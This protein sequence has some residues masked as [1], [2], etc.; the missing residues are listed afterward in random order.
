MRF[1]YNIYTGGAY[2]AVL[3]LFQNDENNERRAELVEVDDNGGTY[4]YDV[5]EWFVHNMLTEKDWGK[6]KACLYKNGLQ[7]D[8]FEN[9]DYV[10]KNRVLINNCFIDTF[11]SKG[12]NS[13]G[14]VVLSQK[15]INAHV[16]QGKIEHGWC[17]NHVKFPADYSGCLE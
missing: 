7:V 8:Q 10:E 2:F 6:L 12:P 1:V 16:I 15:T 4:N 13:K 3:N 5:W 14:L 17:R 9:A 11:G